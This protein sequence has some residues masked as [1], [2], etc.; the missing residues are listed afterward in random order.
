MN[1]DVIIKTNVDD[2]NGELISNFFR[3]EFPPLVGGNIESLVGIITSKMVGSRNY[4]LAGCPNP[5]SEVA[6]RDVIRISIE[7]GKPIPVLVVCGPKKPVIG[8]SIDITE[9]S[10][11]RIL[12]CV[13]RQVQEVY[14]AGLDIRLR[15]EDST[16]YYLEGT[17][18]I[19]HN[20]MEKYITDLSTLVRILGYNNFI[21]PIRET[22]L[23]NYVIFRDTANRLLPLF[24]TYL[25]NS[26]KMPQSEWINLDSFKLLQEKG[27][28]G[29]IPPEMR[30]YYHHRYTLLFPSYSESER[31]DAIAKYFAATLARPKVNGIGANP[32]WNNKFIQI[33]FAPPVTGEPTNRTTTRLYYRTVPL[34]H[35]K[36]H[37]PFW[38]AKGFLKINGSVRISL[39]TWNEE[40]DLNPF[41]VELSKGI[42][43]VIIKADYMFES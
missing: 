40:L 43:K 30:E 17:S 15:I 13:Q 14:P 21:T 27:W 6:I 35:T 19:I 3:V 9:L 5:E 34:S 42:D 31:L 18:E 16:G 12:A 29:I 2:P 20:S 38:R 39:A 28:N 41:E 32:E 25:N 8:E 1:D 33:N 4:R 23:G 11:L 22:S 10:A 26:S 37:L 36:R 7:L 24:E